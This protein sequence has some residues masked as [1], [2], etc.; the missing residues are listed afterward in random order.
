[1]RLPQEIEQ[2][3]FS[4]MGAIYER[5]Y[6]KANSNLQLT[7]KDILKYLGTYWPRSFAETYTIFDD[8]FTSMVIKSILSYKQSL[9]IFD[10]GSGTGGNLIGLLHFVK[11]QFPEKS[12]SIISYDGN[13]EALIQEKEVM[14][15]LFPPPNTQ[16][17]PLKPKNYGDVAKIETKAYTIKIIEKILEQFPCKFDIIMNSKFVNEFYKKDYDKNKGMY[18]ELVQ[19][20]APALSQDGVFVMLDVTDKASNDRFLPQLMNQELLQYL[21]ESSSL[22][23][24]ILPLSCSFWFRECQSPFNCFIQKRVELI[25]KAKPSEEVSKICYKIFTHK[26]LAEALLQPIKKR[27][28]YRLADSD[29]K[30]KSSFCIKGN[31][32]WS[33]RGNHADDPFSFSKTIL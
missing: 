15:K 25:H 1:M 8:L 18:R 32:L 21:K 5:N 30:P 31:S 14:G 20:I 28:E 29:N 10:I 2:C 27:D 16:F 7:E 11:K 4:D 6:E 12:I 33:D 9:T 17:L 13:R 19:V 23:Q 24:C 3:I 22:L 26:A